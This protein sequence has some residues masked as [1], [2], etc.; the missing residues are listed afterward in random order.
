MKTRNERK[1]IRMYDNY[2]LSFITLTYLEAF[3]SFKHTGKRHCVTP[4]CSPRAH[5]RGNSCFSQTGRGI[6]KDDTGYLHILLLRGILL[7]RRTSGYQ[8]MNSLT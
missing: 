2:Q 1:F 7:W 4:G 5:C 6:P 3:R 8:W